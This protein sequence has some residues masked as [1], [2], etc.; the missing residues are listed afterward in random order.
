MVVDPQN[1]FSV[2]GFGFSA[3]PESTHTAAIPRTNPDTPQ[4]CRAIESG[5]SE[6]G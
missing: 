3:A 2:A 1:V 6:T 4:R 5:R